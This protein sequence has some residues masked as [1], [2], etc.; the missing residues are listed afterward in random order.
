MNQ[1][2]EAKALKEKLLTKRRNGAGIVGDDILNAADAYC[3]AYMDFLNHGKTERE[4]VQYAIAEAQKAG[5]I[6]FNPDQRF[7]PG[8]KVFFNNRDKA[9]AFAIFGKKPHREGIRMAAAHVDSPRLDLKP[10]P[11]CEK[12]DLAFFKTH[13]YGGIK[14]YQ[15]TAVPLS[16]HGRIIKKNGDYLDI[17]LGENQNDPQFCVTDLLP[18]LAGEQM[19]KTLSK[20]I[21]GED[22]NILIGS[23]PFRDNQE[24]DLVKLNIMKLLHET[25][26]LVESDFVSAE[27]ELVPAFK[28]AHIGFDRSMIG[29]YGHDDR[30]CAYPAL[31]AILACEAPEHTI[32]TVWAD[33]EEIGSSGN[34]GMQSAWLLHFID[35][36]AKAE[37]SGV[38]RVL[39]RSKCL[40][41]DVG[42][43][44]DPNYSDVYEAGNSGYLN[45]GVL[46]T[47]YT[48]S[49][50]K[51]NTSDASAEFMG[52]IRRLLDQSEVLWQTGE[53]GKVDA[54][55]G[56]TIAKFIAN[57]NV[58][59]VDI[60]VPVLSMHSPFEVVSKLDVYMMHRALSA[61]FERA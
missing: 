19:A 11:L 9:V 60:G 56:G 8:A 35:L 26:G 2:S 39:S 29:A 20:G 31:S 48:G 50:G 49:G 43:A 12:N 1:I 38:S 34:T 55:G 45:Q 58:D 46:I 44:Y 32:M 37:G 30:V 10:C 40:S 4:C 52:E 18:H 42:A 22:L 23:R 33:K 6:P 61:F 53:L 3:G 41:A 13:Y 54:G 17:C 28:A 15:W 51:S 16:L 7:E 47:K 5:F 59:V 27:L 25:Y 14:K 36:L 57:L 24:S 21:Q